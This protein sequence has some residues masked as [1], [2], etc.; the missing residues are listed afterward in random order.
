MRLKCYAIALATV[1][2]PLPYAYGDDGDIAEGKKLYAKECM[3]CHGQNDTAS[4][5]YPLLALSIP[6]TPSEFPRSDAN[7]IAVALPY[8]PNLRGVVGRPAGTFKGF[9]YSKAFLN[10]FRNGT[11]VES[12]LDAWMTDSQAR[13]PDA[14]MFYKQKDPRV[15][16]QIIEYLKAN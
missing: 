1:V 6:L 15:R 13:A 9:Q 2:A 4:R 5:R 7:R 16:R 3:P 11:W 10:A 8:G 14:I 12:E